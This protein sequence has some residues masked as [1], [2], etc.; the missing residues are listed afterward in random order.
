MP[1]K[2]SKVYFKHHY[3]QLPIPFCIYA[4]FEAILPPTK[5]SNETLPDFPS[6]QND[7][8]N[9]EMPHFSPPKPITKTSYTEK[10][11]KHKC[12]G[13]AYKLVCY[14]DDK[15]TKPVR[16]YRG[17]NAA[18][19]FIED[20]IKEEEYCQKMIKNEFN[21]DM[22][23]TVKDKVDF[24]KATKCYICEEEYNSEDIKVRDH[25]HITGKYRGSAH[26]VCNLKYRLSF[27]LPVIFHNLRGY[28]SHFIM[29]EIGKFNL[30]VNVIPD[31]ME[32]YLSFMLGKNIIFL[33][34]FQFMSQSLSKLV[35][36]LPEEELK[37][38]KE[39]FPS[40]FSLM[41]KKGI[42]P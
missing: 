3:K 5:V 8:D 32:K 11:Q 31:N 29:Q 21:K 15:Y 16:L 25:D 1:S 23:L 14:Y 22:I 36:N 18:Y 7:I 28:D 39:R 38:I 9:L 4:D 2:D 40:K 13:F 20:I 6:P 33:D 35:D 24:K 37:Y 27:K 19:K 26:Q 41:R 34:S 30:N 10:Y 17:K 12:C 42:Y